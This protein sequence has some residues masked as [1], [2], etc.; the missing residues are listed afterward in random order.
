MFLLEILIALSLVAL[1]I[2]PFVKQPITMHKAEIKRLERI[3][4]DRIAAWT[5]TEVRETLLN[6]GLRWEQIPQLQEQSSWMGLA[7]VVLELPPM[8]CTHLPRRY[9]LVTQEEKQEANGQIHRLVALV[10]E[11]GKRQFTYRV[12]LTKEPQMPP[13]DETATSPPLQRV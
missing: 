8:P 12:I 1:C 4:C 13:A 10:I 9:R 11:V 7:D 2:F 5:Y 3:E 6:R